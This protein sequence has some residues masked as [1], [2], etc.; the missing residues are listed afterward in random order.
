MSSLV[1]YSLSSLSSENVKQQVASFQQKCCVGAD[2]FDLNFTHCFVSSWQC[3]TT[4]T[5]IMF[6]PG[7]EASAEMRDGFTISS[8]KT[9]GKL[10]DS[11]A[12]D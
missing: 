12:T 7:M 6:C 11:C 2:S 10:P 8:W 3:L 5:E 9:F 4:V 1:F